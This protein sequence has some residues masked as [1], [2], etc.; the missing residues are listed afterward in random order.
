MTSRIQLY[1]IIGL[2]CLVGLSGIIYKRVMLG[3]PLLPK[4]SIPVWV[5]EAKL[6]FKASG[7]PV[8]VSLAVPGEQSLLG[9]LNEEGISRGYGF[10]SAEKGAVN[11]LH[12]RA[13]WARSEANGDQQLF[14]R[15]LAYKKMKPQRLG[16]LLTIEPVVNPLYA[17]EPLLTVVSA[18][19][20]E[21]LAFSA[22]NESLT[23]YVIGLFVED[24]P[25]QN[26]RFLMQGHES[27]VAQ[28]KVI[29]QVL[30]AAGAE[31]H[32]IKGLVLEESQKQQSLVPVILVQNKNKGRWIPFFPNKP[33][34]GIP[35]PFLA[36]QRGGESLVD[37]DGGDDVL[38]RFSVLRDRRPIMEVVKQAANRNGNR[39]IE[40]SLYN[41]PIEQ[42]NTFRML[43]MVPLGALIVVIFRNLVGLKTSGT[44]MPILLAMSFL[45]THLVPGLIIFGLVVGVGLVVRAYLSR[46][47][48]L[49]V[50]RI[51][52]VVI[53]VI[54]I[55]VLMSVMGYLLQLKFAQSV[56]LFPII[57]LAWTVERLSVLW[58]EDGPHEV[59]VQ[60]TG[61]LIT[62][63]VCYFVMGSSVFQY[64]VFT[65]PEWILIVLGVI[66]L[67]G[68]YTGYRLSELRRFGLFMKEE[69]D[70]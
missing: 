70:A 19:V 58:D 52:A 64:M 14:Y 16:P 46:L 65:F 39:F 29:Q 53:V 67:M 61:S 24:N 47:D 20:E 13:V 2:L 28:A 8:K 49:L 43:L 5:V 17:Q 50:P 21:S 18:V 68:Q 6:D 30:L 35:R 54:G 37:V 62:A 60:M 4:Q 26:I 3:Y 44:F 7:K 10:T 31:A 32:L 25:S 22:D 57:I 34:P 9:L 15:V 11:T 33:Q 63:I 12:R 56:T 69:D 55:M 48:L 41:L 45:Q 59:A 36:W 27:E 1:F 51:S 42:Q 40:F 23:S 38:V 66:L